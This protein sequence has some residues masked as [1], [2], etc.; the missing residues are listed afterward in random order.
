[1]GATNA[2]FGQPLFARMTAPAGGGVWN[3][4]ALLVL[5]AAALI[6]FETRSTRDWREYNSKIGRVQWVVAGLGVLAL[7]CGYRRPS[8]GARAEQFFEHGA[9]LHRGRGPQWI[10][11]SDLEK[12]VHTVRPADGGQ[13]WTLELTGPGGRPFIRLRSGGGADGG[14]LGTATAEE[15]QDVSTRASR[16][17]AER[18]VRRVDRGEV[19]KWADGVSVDPAGLRINGSVQP[20]FIPWTAID[21]VKDGS[22]SGNFE[23]YAF[24]G[25][26]LVAAAPA[27]AVNA[28]PIYHAFL[29]LLDRGQAAAKSSEPVT[30]EAA[31][32]AWAPGSREP[33]LRPR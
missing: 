9:C 5:A 8:R 10:A 23:I 20:R 24:G 17:V 16:A 3:V 1:M 29:Q 15:I 30:A 21:G 32:T 14:A 7:C 28:L 12:V 22:Q 6:A 19:V 2:R 4:A 13:E 26:E 33:R 31:V 11:Y 18:I 25:Q 27:H